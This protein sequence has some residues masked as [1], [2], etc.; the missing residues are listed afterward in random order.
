MR[1]LTLALPDDL[2]AHLQARAASKGIPLEGFIVEQ[3]A[4]GTMARKQQD[5]EKR[6]LHEVLSS[7][8]L[9]QPISSELVATYVSDLAAPR[10]SPVQVRGKPLSAVIIEQR[11]G[12][13]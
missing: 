4:A 9:L 13:E 1:E 8:G 6:L 5:E 7:T 11:T 3:L 2:Y 10:Q 12:L